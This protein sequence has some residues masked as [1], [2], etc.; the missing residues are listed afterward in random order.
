MLLIKLEVL[1]ALHHVLLELLY[2]LT[3]LGGLDHY[4][5]HLCLQVHLL[6]TLVRHCHALLVEL[7]VRL[8]KLHEEQ[9]IVTYE[10][11]QSGLGVESCTV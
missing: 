6:Q 4:L 5:T 8:H 9:V 2:L 7:K 10:G 3:T 11:G 1:T